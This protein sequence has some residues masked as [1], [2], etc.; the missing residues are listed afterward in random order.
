MQ[1]PARRHQ[2]FE[3]QVA[4]VVAGVAVAEA[5]LRGD[6]VEPAVD[7]DPRQR[8]L[9]EAEHRDHPEGNRAL[10]HHAAERDATGEEGLP[11][12]HVPEALLEHASDHVVADHR[13][14]AGFGRLGRERGDRGADGVHRRT[15]RRLV[16]VDREQCVD[17]APEFLRPHRRLAF[18]AGEGTPACEFAE[19]RIERAE[20][21]RAGAVD[22]ADRGDRSPAAR[23]VQR[24]RRSLAADIGQITGHEALDAPR[25][26]PAPGRGHALARAVVGIE[27]PGDARVREPA[28]DQGN[29]AFA[30]PQ[31]AAHLGHV[32]PVEHPRHVDA[33]RRQRQQV[34]HR[35]DQGMAARERHVAQPVRQHHVL[36]H[37][38]FAEHRLDQR[39]IAADVRRHHADVLRRD[40]TVLRRAATGDRGEQ[41]IA[42]DL[43]LAHAGVAGVDA[44]RGVL[45][46]LAARSGGRVLEAV[47]ADAVL[48]A[49]QQIRRRRLDPVLAMAHVEADALA[50]GEAREE[51][52]AQP[53]PARQQ[54]VRAVQRWLVVAGVDA[55]AHPGR[56]REEGL[57]TGR[58]TDPVVAARIEEVDADRRVPREGL[59]H[60]ELRGREMRD[61]EDVQRRPRRG[62]AAQRLDQVG[63]DLGAM[64]AQPADQRAPQRRQ[65][66]P[67]GRGAE[68]MAAAPPRRQMVRPIDEVPRVDP[69]QTIGQFEAPQ[70]APGVG[71]AR[72]AVE[73][74]PDR[75]LGDADR[76]RGAQQF[77]E[78]PAHRRVA[79]GRQ[80]DGALAEH[81]LG[82]PVDEAARQH[83]IEVR[84][85]RA[86]AAMARQRPDQPLPH[87][88]VP[89]NDRDRLQ[90]ILGREFREQ[91]VE[92]RK[93]RFETTGT[94]Q[95]D[96]RRCA[97]AQSRPLM[98][99]PGLE[100]LMDDVGRLEC[101]V[102]RARCPP[103][104]CQ[105]A[106]A[107]HNSDPAPAR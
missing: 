73:I 57:A 75:R 43:Q 31:P 44:Q 60:R 101:G 80:A 17:A 63:D 51:L 16:R 10:R 106:I 29:V 72:V 1:A 42:Q 48:D 96:S 71:L 77:V 65:Q 107:K 84:D 21:G 11:F 41:G 28:F 89:G 39:R 62:L 90:R 49:L 100:S 85:D 102:G 9:V 93:Q 40:A 32:E 86:R 87:A 36:A 3:E 30:K 47:R 66:L 22:A 69:R 14:E 82:Q 5:G 79:P 70:A 13:V 15:R 58:Q 56:E 76:I 45:A 68:R 98:E 95:H 23:R 20:R 38:G 46:G 52:L 4:V 8:A 92:G 59:Q 6:R 37:A 25:E 99:L 81:R 2:R 83:E 61:A 19:Q 12:G 27:R 97:L 105:R 88:G 35:A 18:A 74:A 34:Q 54:R 103:R 67:L 104:D 50:V 78:R 7:R 26:G 91:C 55:R 24:R 94:G 53:P 33:R 64:A